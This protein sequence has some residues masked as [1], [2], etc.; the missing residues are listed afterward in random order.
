MGV[1]SLPFSELRANIK[2]E[3][4]DPYQNCA[5]EIKNTHELLVSTTSTD[6]DLNFVL[7]DA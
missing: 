4:K 3:E 1:D 5:V 6:E 2:F 7:A